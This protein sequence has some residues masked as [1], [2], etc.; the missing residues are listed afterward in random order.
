MAYLSI[1]NALAVEGDKRIKILAVLEPA[2]FSRRQQIPSMSEA[3]PSFRKPSSWFGFFG[4]AGVPA[5][6]VA[7]LNGEIGKALAGAD[8]RQKLDANGMALL[9]G[10]PED[11]A[12]LI[13]DG[14][15]RYG[16]II[17]AAGVKA[18]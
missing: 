4:P 11:F 3:L 14:M 18:E 7:R 9:G 13:A 12:A 6:I 2:R 17:K 8:V 1:S 10:T 15:T 16:A 5:A